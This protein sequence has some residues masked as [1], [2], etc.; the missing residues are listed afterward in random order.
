MAGRNPDSHCKA[1]T[2]KGEPCRAAATAGGLCFFHANPNKASELGRIGG[3]SKGIGPVNNAQPLPTLDSMGAVRDTVD[4]LI[5]DVYAGRL[6]PKI[7][8][9]LA[10]LLQLQLR[11]LDATEVEGR[12]SRLERLA[13]KREQISKNNPVKYQPRIGPASGSFSTPVSAPDSKEESES[14]VTEAKGQ[15]ALQN[16]DKGPT[17]K[18]EDNV[19][20]RGQ[21]LEIQ[22]HVSQVEGPSPAEISA[23]AP[24]FDTSARAPETESLQIPATTTDEQPVDNRERTQTTDAPAI[25]RKNLA[26]QFGEQF[27]ELWK[28]YPLPFK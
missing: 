10:P 5:A 8:A 16:R 7:A 25:D 12:L 26:G 19:V 28:G 17:N 18:R 3:R 15:S 14:R 6:H 11:A 24:P 9:V 22:K 27:R 20:A 1:L 2:K 23:D 21:E 4:R 13:A